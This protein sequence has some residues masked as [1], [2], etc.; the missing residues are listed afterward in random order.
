M[1][2]ARKTPRGARPNRRGELA[3]LVECVE[4]RAPFR[5]AKAKRE[6]E[7]SGR[8][9][10]PGRK[11]GARGMIVTEHCCKVVHRTES[12]LQAHPPLF[13][14]LCAA[15]ISNARASFL[16]QFFHLD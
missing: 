16:L 3:R 13:M 6:D 12:G 4:R 9:L 7:P 14:C 2:S 10:D 15:G 11:A 8:S 1:P 5:E